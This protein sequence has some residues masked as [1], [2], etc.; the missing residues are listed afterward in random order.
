[1]STEFPR[2]GKKFFSTPAHC[3]ARK[4]SFF[5]PCILH[6]SKK[7]FFLLPA[8]CMARKK[9]FFAPCT[10]HGSKKSFFAD[11]IDR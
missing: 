7:K 4:K 1:M 8:Y 11:Q 5:A 3:E 6:D 9:S 10:L 2:P